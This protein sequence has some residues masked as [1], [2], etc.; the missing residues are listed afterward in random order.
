MNCCVVVLDPWLLKV[1][2]QHT[3]SIAYV[4]PCQVAEVVQAPNEGSVVD[5]ELLEFS[6]F[7]KGCSSQVCLLVDWTGCYDRVFYIEFLKFALYVL[8]LMDV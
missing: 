5:V 8:C 1:L 6:V 7:A 4:Q 3:Y 2:R